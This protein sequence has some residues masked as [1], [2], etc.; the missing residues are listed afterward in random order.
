MEVI[1]GNVLKYCKNNPYYAAKIIVELEAKNA[2]LEDRLLE[3]QNCNKV[4]QS[5]CDELE[6]EKAELES[7]WVMAKAMLPEK[8]K[9]NRKQSVKVINQDG[10]SVYYSYGYKTWVWWLVVDYEQ[11]RINPKVTHWRPLPSPPKQDY[12]GPCSNL[13]VHLL[14]LDKQ[15]KGAK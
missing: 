1:R 15:D 8:S 9:E 4:M 11:E 14:S 10:D 2:E 6:L 7:E 13:N 5:E 3:H 12:A